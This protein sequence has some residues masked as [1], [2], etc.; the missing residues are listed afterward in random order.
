MGRSVEAGT[1]WVFGGCDDL[2]A[3]D[4]LESVCG[5]GSEVWITG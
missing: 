3:C 5:D 1:K 4:G 2:D